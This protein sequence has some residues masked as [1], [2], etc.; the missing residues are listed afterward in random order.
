MF[1]LIKK[2]W[3]RSIRRQLLLGI[4]LVHAVLMTI[5]V[6]DLVGRQRNFLHEQSISNTL[7]LSQSL[8]SNAVS[9][10]LAHDVIGLEEVINSQAQFPDLLYAMVLSP[11]GKVLGHS[12][13]SKVGLYIAD[14]VSCS[15]IDAYPVS[16]YLITDEELVD[17]ASPILANERLV[18][19][20]RVGISQGKINAGLQVI[21][22]DGVYYTIFAIVVGSIFALFMARGLTRGI[23]HLVRGAGRIGTGKEEDERIIALDRQDELGQLGN[24][25]NNML[26]RIIMQKRATEEARQ[27]L[28]ERETYLR[29]LVETL[30]DLVWLKNP[31]GNY[32]ECNRKFELLFGAKKAEIIGKTDYDFV[33]KDLADFSR[34]KDRAVMAAGRSIVNEEEVT[35][36]ADGHQEILETIKTPMYGGDGA[37]IGVLGVGRDITER[38]KN[39]SIIRQSREKWEKTFN[40]IPDIVSL[41]DQ[42]M[43]IVKINRAGCDALNLEYENII[44]KHCYELFTGS[45]EC[46]PECP[47]LE[48][49]ETPEPYTRE[50]VHKKSGRTF[51]VSAAPILN[52]QGELTNIVHA[53]KDVS[54]M[55]KMEDDLAQ[56]QKMEAIGTLAGGIAHDFNNILSIIIGHSELAKYGIPPDSKAIEDIDKVLGASNR[57][58]DLVRHILTFSRKSD[59]ALQPLAPHLI[60]KEAIKMLRA[61]L[62]TTILMREDIDGECGKIMANP[63][64]IHQI[65]V[66]LCTN[67]LHAMEKE[68]GVLGI[69]LYRKEINDEE[70]AGESGVSP[71]P[72][73]VLE[74]SD[75]GK[76]MD[77]RTLERIFE[78]YFTTKEV[79]KGTGLGLAVVLGIVQ[80]YKG[81]IRVRSKPG[82][83]TAFY[84]YIPAMVDELNDKI[85]E[86]EE[87]REYLPTG[88]ERILV[89]DDERLVVELHKHVLEKLGYQVTSL[90][91]GINALEAIRAHPGSF[92]LIIT[93][94]TMPLLTGAD[95]AREALKIKPD[96]P[97]I[98]CTGYSSILSAEE[99]LAM[100]IK[101]Y[102]KKP[103]SRTTLA[104]VVR[105][106]LDKKG[107]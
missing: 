104:N 46:C 69:K 97:I 78:P 90:D 66:N 55:K 28:R 52:E 54:E 39:E 64:N 94:Q 9:W 86:V 10:V 7:S 31:E 93:D 41:L 11:D 42:D 81:F 18:G 19:W 103:V 102:L 68:K 85:S 58:A 3:T 71:G 36:A 35:Y 38:K 24:A 1:S 27:S 75:T 101:K 13:R 77:K 84:V 57:A 92:D 6:F 5:F 21:T 30:P 67:S 51:L 53:A 26:D 88:N 95:L 22:R 29:T 15:L 43:H 4:A 45:D 2:I 56:A 59:H 60:I 62:P 79:G 83:G 107:N 49:R 63:T 34:E 87:K 70:I 48:A 37:L 73:I 17:I 32:L 100:G 33:G 16:H 76:G 40:A 91:N 72:F 47:I 74:V 65:I 96:L 82:A 8:A 105:E 98:L 14:P 44:G 99:A 50:M 80:E 12:E 106:L 25:L 89:V 61:S 23:A 20:A